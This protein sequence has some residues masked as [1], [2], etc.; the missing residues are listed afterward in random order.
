MLAHCV[1]SREMCNV[2]VV[3][4]VYAELDDDVRQ[5]DN[6]IVSRWRVVSA[7]QQGEVRDKVDEILRP[8]GSETGLLVISR[9]NGIAVCFICRTLSAVMSLR[10]QWRSRELRVIVEDLFTFL[11]GV[12]DTVEVKRLAWPLT[13]YERHLDFFSCVQGKHLNCS[14]VTSTHYH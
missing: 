1:L 14:Y 11:S 4:G 9:D 2:S 8:L 13:D 10:Y 6:I 12:T 7:D 3:V 5:S